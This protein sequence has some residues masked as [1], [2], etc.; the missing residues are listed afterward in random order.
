MA[1]RSKRYNEALKMYDKLKRY[2][3]EEAIKVLKEFPST[4]FD[5]SIDMSVR[6][7]LKKNQRIRGIVVFP[8]TFGKPKRVIVFAKGEK[9]EEARKAGADF[10]GDI[11][12]I[13]KIQKGW[14]DFDAAVATPDMMRDVSK[15]GP[16]LGRR[17]LMPNPKTG[18]VTFDIKEAVE[19]I[20]K[21]KT[22]YRS[23]RDGV[24]GIAVAKIS[25]DIQK[26]IDNIIAFYESLVK[27]RPADV[28]GEYI[29]S[30]TLS[31]TMS[32]GVKVDTKTLVKE[33]R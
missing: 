22:D 21:G 3:V 10:V 19:E 8:H 9:A 13:Q 26:I 7:N 20:K 17:G 11:D 14:L 32:P 31:K 33:K 18:T 30:V 24:V 1:K 15:L 5:E 16:I 6:L 2:P 23:D 28:K 27:T 12:L 25:M 29:K 4:K